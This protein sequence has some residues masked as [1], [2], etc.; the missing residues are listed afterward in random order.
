M[1]VSDRILD[2]GNDRRRTDDADLIQEG[3]RSGVAL[4]DDPEEVPQRALDLSLGGRG[5]PEAGERL[6][7]LALV[8]LEELQRV[9]GQ[10]RPIVR[11]PR[12]AVAQDAAERRHPAEPAVG[13]EAA[14]TLDAS[15]DL[16]PDAELVGEVHLE[17]ARDPTRLH[18][19]V[20]Q[21]VAALQERVDRLGGVTLLEAPVRELREVPR[22][23][24]AL[25]R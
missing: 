8:C 10:S 2:A 9:E 1:R 19:R 7:V 5:E 21:L 17:P 18:A 4:E 22:G 6:G 13:L 12:T 14:V 11:R 3:E 15:V 16:G 24:R 23:C 25:E 20:E